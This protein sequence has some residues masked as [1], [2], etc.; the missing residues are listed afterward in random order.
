MKAIVIRE[1]GG[2]EVLRLEDAPDPA[3]TRDEVLVRVRACGVNNLDTQI[4]RG[5]PGVVIALPH[6]LGCDVAGEVAAL[7]TDA[8]AGRAAGTAVREAGAAGS[9]D[10]LGTLSVG[11]RVVVSPG[12]GCGVC[13]ACL[14]GDD[15]ACPRYAML[16]YQRRGGYAEL[17]SVPSRSVIRVSDRWSFE[18]WASA[19]LVFLT[20]WHM[21]MTRA[22]LRPAETVLVHAAGSGVGIAAIQIARRAGARVIAT[23]GSDGKLAKARALGAEAGVNYTATGWHKEVRSLTAGE[24]VDV[25]VEH[26]GASTWSGSLAS[27]A[28]RGRLVTCGATTGYDVPI[29]IRH[30]F[31]KQLSLIGSYM[32]SQRELIDAIVLLERGE[33]SPIVDSVFPLSE[34]SA[35]HERVA[36]RALFGKICLTT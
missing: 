36:S 34:A 9:H 33:L 5:I 21:L 11:D 35:A 28:R 19:P 25:V 2:P 20:A 31:V 8:N 4:R 22:R 18:E 7:G 1:H 15:S 14:A 10:P 30:L 6:I 13:R 3:P 12:S 26:T 27:L 29:D 17:V 24:G 23:A 32:G 16:G